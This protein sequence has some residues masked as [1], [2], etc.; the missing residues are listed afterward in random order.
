MTK[1]DVIIIGGG[2][3]GY[4]AAIR[5]RQLG[6][7]VTLIEKEHL[8]GVCLNWGCI[9]TKA[10]LRSAEIA[11]ML[12]QAA[13]FGFEI[14]PPQINLAKMVDRSRK[15]AAQLSGGIRHLMKKN[16]V[17]VVEGHAQ[18]VK[19]GHVR[20]T[21][22]DGTSSEL[23]ASHIILAT[24]ARPRALPNI[25]PDGKLIWTSREAMVPE[26]LPKSMLI[27]GSGA[28]GIEF[29]SFY[30]ALGTEVTVLEIQNRIL[31][32]EDEEISTYAQK[33]F[34]KQGIKF[35]LESQ[36][37]SLHKHKDNLDVKI[38]TPQGES[39]LTVDRLLL[40][41]GIVGNTENLGLEATKVRVEKS[42][43]ITGEWGQTDEPSIYAIGDIA[44]PPWLAHKGSHE[45]IACIEKIAQVPGAHPLKHENIPGCTYSIPQI[46][47]IGLTEAHAKETG[48][49]IK[50]GRFPFRANGKALA[51]GESE[52]LV[53]VIFA[54]K[55]GKLLG[56]HM[57]GHEVT[58]LIQGFAIAKTGE[59][60]EAE[61]MQTI[62]PHPTLSEM[63]HESVLDAFGRAIHS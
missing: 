31:P 6:L 41:V 58:E 37:V 24:G 44:G 45:G 11:H 22:Q 25:E 13:D 35:L 30:R 3:G 38:K 50:V 34:E 19:A 7:S 2:P 39:T 42:H 28:I 29:A 62:F 4:V 5:G 55:T 61:L 54:E 51:L 1:S 16:Q 8:G 49:A 10:L 14:A 21:A 48:L 33:A 47:S 43:I 23:Q 63:I 12:H 9:P 32:P 15:I 26:R 59:L 20:V 40:A 36:I 56:A 52:G 17:T 60:T 46:A 53:K 18:L 27:V 57:V